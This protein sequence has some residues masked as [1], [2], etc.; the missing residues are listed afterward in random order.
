MITTSRRAR[1]APV[2]LGGLLVSLTACTVNIGT[3]AAS[4][5]AR[6]SAPSAAQSTTIT[7]PGVTAV[8]S[9]APGQN[10]VAR[11]N[12]SGSSCTVT[13]AGNSRLTVLGT[14]L[15]LQEVKDGRATLDVGGQSVSCGPGETATAGPLTL[16]CTDVT[17]DSV[18]FT[19]SLS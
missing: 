9:A 3:T 14:S 19:A 2:V 15:A 17:A 5:S 8:Q 12:C 16:R 7:G 1:W 10:N 11:V 4:S 6:T 18:S 13:L